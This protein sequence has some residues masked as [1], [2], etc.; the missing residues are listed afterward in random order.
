MAFTSGSRL[1]PYEILAPL[2][3]GGMGEVYRARDTRLD[4]TVAIKILPPHLSDDPT[5]RQ[6]FE[7]E[8]KAISSLNHPHICVLYDVGSQDGAQFLVMEC[9]EGETLA[10]R[11]EKGPLPL[12]QVLKNGTQIADALDK[13]HRNGVVH[14]DLKPGNI[15][16]TASGA[17]LLDFGLAKAPA[18]AAGATLTA[19]LTPVTQQGTVVGTFQ[20]MSP[21]QIEGKDVDARTDIFSFGSVLYEMVTGRRAFPGKTQLSVASA[22]LEKEPEPIRTLQPLAPPALDRSIRRCLAKDPEDRWQTARDLLLELRWIAEVGS[23]AGVPAPVISPRN[24]LER[25]AWVGAALGI[26]LAVIAAVGWWRADRTSTRPA[27]P[28]WLTAQIGSGVTLVTTPPGPFFAL[29]SDGTRLA[30]EGQSGDQKLRLYV[31][32]LD[33]L[34]PIPLSDTDGAHQPFFSPDGQWLG[35]FAD[36]K[37]RKILVQGGGAATLCGVGDPRGGSWSE[38]GS[39]I[40]GNNVGTGE[41]FKVS[42]AAGGQAEPLTTL[43]KNTGEISHRY[44]QVLPGGKA[45]LFTA[46]DSGNFEN[47][48]IK[49]YSLASHQTKTLVRGGFYGHYLLSGHLAYVHGGTLF[50]VPFDLNRL[51]VTGNPEPILGGVMTSSGSGDAQIAFSNT[52]TMVY[53]SGPNTGL[54]VSVYWMDGQG[55]FQPLL[56]TPA[57]YVTPRFSPDGKRLA[58]AICDEEGGCDVWIYDLDR[59]TPTRITFGG[60]DFNPAWTPDGQR[61]TYFAREKPGEA[62]IYWKRADGAGDAQRLTKSNS[63]QLRFSWRPDGKVLAFQER[64]STTGWDIMTVTVEGNENS[65]WK[66]SEPKPFLNSPSQ[67]VEPAFSPDGRWLAYSSNESGNFEVYV[68]PFPGPGGKWQISSGGCCAKWSANG[69]E[70]FYQTDDRKIMVVSYAVRGD[71]FHADKPRLWSTEQITSRGSGLNFDLHPDGKRFAVLRAAGGMQAGAINTINITFNFFEELRGKVPTV[72][73]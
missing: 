22:I 29:S 26:V 24:V 64:N 23:Q 50:A 2:G 73:N 56:Q 31:R 15:M 38:D 72:K 10:K 18:L 37:L 13:A 70:L 48:N 58:L 25:L 3:T 19:A 35:F 11:L 4:R 49:V 40:F 8:A 71:S 6:R 55:K 34:Q 41:L 59:Q 28:V 68:R 65:G 63:P 27:Q 1:G 45:V 16:L 17:K 20:Y 39:I 14:R 60:A 52:G 42:S 47:A 62:G 33:Q 67:E 46:T 7:R 54:N 51:E 69:K 53:V 36:G 21:E 61:I 5:L 66:A 9:V 44:P 57:D 30:F 32:T 43:D 12:E